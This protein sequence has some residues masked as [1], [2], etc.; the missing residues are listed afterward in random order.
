MRIMKKHLMN[1]IIRYFLK[2]S[3]LLVSLLL[4]LIPTHSFAN[5]VSTSS[6]DQV[7]GALAEVVKDRAKEVATEAIKERLTSELCGD[8]EKIKNDPEKIKKIILDN[9]GIPQTFYLGG[10]QDC[11]NGT[12]ECNSDN[13]FVKTCRIIK[14]EPNLQLTDP[15]FLKTLSRDTV[16]FAVRL[17]AYKLNNKQ[18]ESL[19]L[20]PFTNFIHAVMEQLAKG[21]TDMGAFSGEVDELVTQYS[22]T[23]ENYAQ[24]IS[25]TKVAAND[26]DITIDEL[27]KKMDKDI[28]A[29]E[30]KA[31]VIKDVTDEGEK[32][33]LSTAIDNLM[34]RPVDLKKIKK[35]NDDNDRIFIKL[36]DKYEVI[37]TVGPFSEALYAKCSDAKLKDA[38]LKNCRM[39]QLTLRLQDMLYRNRAVT[40]DI[41]KNQASNEAIKGN[42]RRLLYTL[43]ESEIYREAVNGDANFI[44]KYD[45]FSKATIASFEKRVND[46][47]ITRAAMLDTLRLT[48]AVAQALTHEPDE[49]MKWLKQFQND[50]R[51]PAIDSL[52]D[53]RSMPSLDWLKKDKLPYYTGKMKSAF[54]QMLASPQIYLYSWKGDKRDIELIVKFAREMSSATTMITSHDADDKPSVVSVA[55]QLSTFIKIISKNMPGHDKG[56][57]ALQQFASSLESISKILKH[58]QERDWVAIG[59]DINDRIND[60]VATSEKLDSLPINKDDLSLQNKRIKYINGELI[61]IGVMTEKEKEDLLK[62]SIDE[63]YKSAIEKLS[64]KSQKSKEFQ[65]GL[66]FGRTLL[67]MYQASSVE[68][69][70]GIFQ[71][72]LESQSSRKI[73]YEQGWTVDVAA[74][75]GLRLGN[76]WLDWDKSSANNDSDGFGYGIYAPFGVQFAYGRFGSMI[77][78]IDLGGYISGSNA[79]KTAEIR[80]QSALHGG[81]AIYWRPSAK[82]PIVVGG[83]YDYKP[84]FG[85]DDSSEHRVGGFMALELPLFI[86]K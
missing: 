4:V 68:E 48:A 21:K 32:E 67:S 25:E 22:T 49:A 55:N 66:R 72:T 75:V 51:N 29:K 2:K 27:L 3:H 84:R 43:D 76:V 31:L 81:A 57:T 73:R 64:E 69:A 7:L 52:S 79:D 83:S 42:M 56:N 62:L 70:K 77:Y 71:A 28:F 34:K 26:L 11:R 19:N 80:T 24:I 15:Y 12:E 60:K 6:V 35:R 54:K 36:F 86:I 18:F 16:G 45:A 37:N 5:T 14:N 53:L 82:M 58:T 78:P 63:S 8:E 46:G 33:I 13:L 9:E 40:E 30:L 65:N 1:E 41:D 47:W 74:L 61:F 50:L 20:D 17:S 44:A 59:F 10:T 39:A 23:D 38:E 85:D